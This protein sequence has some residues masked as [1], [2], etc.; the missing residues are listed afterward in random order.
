[1]KIKLLIIFLIFAILSIVGVF[2]L[3]NYY[4]YSTPVEK[5]E[6]AQITIDQTLGLISENREHFQNYEGDVISAKK[7]PLIPED[8]KTNQK[9][10]KLILH[11]W[12]SWCDP[13]VNEI[14]QL[15]AYLKHHAADIKNNKL[16]VILVSVD[17]E[18]PAIAK[19]LKSFPELNSPLY[20]QLWDPDGYLQ[21]GF[22]IDRLPATLVIHKTAIGKLPTGNDKFIERYMAVVNWKLMP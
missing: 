4:L 1:M 13:C 5:V 12:A 3:K 20:L 22:N 16:K 11:F 2:Y 6:E 21:K 19:F 14:P 15:L 18:Q 8:E 7:L 9:V 10:E 17:Y